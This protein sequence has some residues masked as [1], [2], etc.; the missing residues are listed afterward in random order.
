M[1]LEIPENNCYTVTVLQK[2]HKNKYRIQTKEAWNPSGSKPL[3]V[4]IHQGIRA[5]ALLILKDT[6]Y[7][8]LLFIL[9]NLSFNHFVPTILVGACSLLRRFTTVTTLWARLRKA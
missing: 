7:A 3:F 5:Y 9:Y 8:H 6:A 1:K 2:H 4:S